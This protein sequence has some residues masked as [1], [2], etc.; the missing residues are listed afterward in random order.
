VSK[1]RSHVVFRAYLIYFGFVVIMLIVLYQIIQLQFNGKN[2]KFGAEDTVIPV[3]TVARTPR[4][5]DILDAHLLPLLTSVSY[6]DIHMDPT[7]VKQEIFDNEL[8]GLAEGLNRLYPIKTT[9]EYENYIRSGRVNG[10]RYLLIRKKATNAERKALRK[11]PIFKEGRMKGG[12]IDN[13]D[14]ITRKKPNG[15]LLNR[16]LG[17]YKVVDGVPLK[18]GIEGAYYNYLKG[19]TGAEIEQKISI[20]WRK[21]G[22]ITKEAIEGADVVATIEKDIQEVAHSELEKQLK[23]MD[24]ESGSV[25]VMEVNTGYVRAIVNLS[26]E[27]NGEFAENFNRAFGYVEAPGSTFKLASLMAALEDG[28]VK[29]TD[30]VNANGVYSFYGSKLSDSNHGIGYGTITLQEAFEKSSNVIAQVINS[31]YSKN[32]QRFM[33]RMDAFGIT[34]KLGIDL[35]GEA[36]PD[37]ARPGDAGWSPLSIPW[38]AIGY[39]VRQSP[40]QTLAFYNAVANNGNLMRPIFVQSIRRR[41]V[42]I[43]KFLP[44]VLRKNIC[45]QKTIE[46]LKKCLEGVMSRGTGS[47]LTSSQFK[48]AGKTGTTKL[49]GKDKQYL[50]ESNSVYQAS[51][52]GYFPADKPKY[53]CIVVITDPKKEYYGARVS[54]TVFA[55]I[56]NKVWASSLDYHQAINEKK[57]I[58][59]D[60]PHVKYG[61]RNDLIKSLK[62]LGIVFKL[63]FDSDWLVA[64]TLNK[65][66]NL[67]QLKI[68]KGLVPNVI[69]MTA[70]DAV[71]LLENVGMIVRIRGYGSVKNQSI[72]AGNLVFKGGLIQLQLQ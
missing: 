5:G 23:E 63:N 6:F 65:K 54:G 44:I 29:I 7:V 19:E 57:P 28:K 60:L 21:T 41:G 46:I 13:E 14:T 43:K 62:V 67:N 11:L 33:D 71:Y 10:S 55:E 27:K 34:Q 70:K 42:T 17:Y 9:R 12:L 15:N 49:P 26:R 68:A 24:A 38:M 18:V 3:R 59:K 61:H 72:S 16:T 8:G 31:L 22:K 48:I 50:D 51:F 4:M 58:N 35:E 45:S 2:T 32:P 53:S 40:M 37:F 1:E 20:G 30:K 47:S 36:A 64:D 52:V 69:G 66:V 39:G 56:A 25:I